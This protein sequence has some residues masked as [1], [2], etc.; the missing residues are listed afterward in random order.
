MKVIVVQLGA[1]HRYAVP[2][3]LKEAGYLEALYTDSNGS[4]GLG[5]WLGTVPAAILPAAAKRLRQ[6]RI[7]VLPSHSVRSTDLLLP[8]D[9]P[10]RRFSACIFDCDARRDR[11]FS[12]VL[13]RWGFGQATMIYSMFGEG[14]KFLDAAKRRGLKIA[15]DMFVNPITHRIVESERQTFPEWEA[16][17]SSDFHALEEHADKCIA[18]AD[19][20]LCPADAVADGMKYYPSFAAEKI[21]VVPYGFAS[22]AKPR[23][24]KPARRRIL[25]GGSAT[26]RKGIHYFAQAAEMLSLSA[27]GYEFRVAGPASG[28][29]QAKHECRFLSFLGPLTR[30]DF[31]AELESCDVFVLP[32]LAEGSAT[33]I[34][35]ALAMGVPVV[36]TRSAGS[37]VT[38]GK[39]GY[40]VPERDSAALAQAI[41]EITTN[42]KI[43]DA[44]SEAAT[45]TAQEYSEAKWGERLIAALQSIPHLA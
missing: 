22:D 14:W 34:Y 4:Y 1:R 31:M 37:V 9:P 7:A 5:R 36:T 24:L 27:Y 17:G 23:G 2:R 16:P 6:R 21:R 29:V 12:Y 44:M 43:R 45:Q 15:L 33:V 3:L 25:F 10:F 42:R 30:S 32:T 28:I 40:I 20:L 18:L 11:V 26:L 13:S 41:K 19:L 8:F 35:E 38:N 39:E